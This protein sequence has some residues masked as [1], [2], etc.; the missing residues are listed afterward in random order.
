MNSAQIAGI[1]RAIVIGAAGILA[2]HGITE[3]GS[4]IETEMAGLTAAL[5]TW[6]SY[7][8]NA[9]KPATVEQLAITPP[10]VITA[11]TIAPF[12]AKQAT[13]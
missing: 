4:L 9:V 8:S 6:W 5:T 1:V 12:A 2:H 13:D 11:A 10:G 3:S 7:R